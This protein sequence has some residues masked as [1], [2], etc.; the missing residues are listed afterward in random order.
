[1]R[2]GLICGLASIAVASCSAGTIEDAESTGVEASEAVANTPGPSRFDASEAVR[3]MGGAF[4]T[5]LPFYPTGKPA[6][7][8][9]GMIGAQAVQSCQVCLVML[10]AEQRPYSG[11]P[12]ALTFARLNIPMTFRRAI[13]YDQPDA[14][15]VDHAQ[16][17]WAV[18]VLQQNGLPAPRVPFNIDVRYELTE[19]D[20]AQF[21]INLRRSGGD[22]YFSMSRPG[23]LIIFPNVRSVLQE[24]ASNDRALLAMAYDR[25]GACN[26]PGRPSSAPIL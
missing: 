18:E 11:R 8:K 1:M 23:K 6:S 21:G 16:G 26:G 15:P 12:Q 9:A 3:R 2:K 14:M 13:S 19:A 25:V 5:G 17:V 10:R 7:C 20:F 22:L 24:L 4:G